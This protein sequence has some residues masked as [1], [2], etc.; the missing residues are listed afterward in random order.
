MNVS[1]HPFDKHE[2]IEEYLDTLIYEYQTVKELLKKGR[3][4]RYN[5]EKKEK[6]TFFL[7]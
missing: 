5:K 1:N 4:I 6:M 2:Y 3:E 7:N